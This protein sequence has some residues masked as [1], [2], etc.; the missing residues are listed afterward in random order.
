MLTIVVQQWHTFLV[1]LQQ[2]THATKTS[3][4][5]ANN[6]MLPGDTNAA[7]KNRAQQRR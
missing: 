5:S 6:F 3:F 2:G 4:P 1:D 7:L